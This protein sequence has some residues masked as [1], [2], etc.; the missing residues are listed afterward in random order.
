MARSWEEQWA[1]SVR[2][3]QGRR[4][5]VALSGAQRLAAAAGSRAPGLPASRGARPA[6]GPGLR[7]DGQE[8]LR[9]G[10]GARGKPELGPG[11]GCRRRSRGAWGNLAGRRGPSRQEI[12]WRPGR[13]PELLLLRAVTGRR[14]AAGPAGAELF[15]STSTLPRPRS[16]SGRGLARGPPGP[17]MP[18]GGSVCREPPGGRRCPSTAL[19]SPRAGA[20]RPPPAAP[21]SGGAARAA[22]ALAPPPPAAHSASPSGSLAR[23]SF[24]PPWPP[25]F[26]TFTY[27]G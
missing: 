6:R 3:T 22:R 15:P 23:P 10:A 25:A 1:V 20:L 9:F 27:R 18:A 17:A 8:P 2:E 11:A 13:G 14:F 5:L 24:V 12:C 7:K 16:G 26:S 21:S 19:P 4:A